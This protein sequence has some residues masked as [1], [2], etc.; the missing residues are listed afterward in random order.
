M[1]HLKIA[2]R[3]R[4]T[5]DTSAR[6]TL[7]PGLELTVELVRSVAGI[8][9]LQADYAHLQAV[10]GNTLPFGLYEWHL[11]WC[12]HFLGQD[13]H[14][15]DRPVFHVLRNAEGVCVAIIPLIFSQRRV[16]AFQAASIGLLGADPAITEIHTWL[17]Q[18]GY[19]ECAAVA[20]HARLRKARDW[21][22]LQWSGPCDEF[23]AALAHL[24]GFRWQPAAPS[25]VLDLP[26]T[27]DEFRAG[28]KRNIRESLRH[29][30]NSLKRDGHRFEFR[31]AAEPGAVRQALDRLV[32]L[33]ALR[34]AMPGT[35]DHPDR[36]AHPGLR[37]FVYEVC[38]ALAA[39]G[40]AR[41]FQLEIGGQIVAARVGFVVGASLYLYYSGFDPAWARYSV[42]TT[43]VA[44][45]LKY[46][47][48]QRLETVNLS[49]G[50]DISKTRWGP[51][52]VPHQVA[53]EHS[54]RLRSRLVRHAYLKAKSGEG[55]Q[56]WLLQRLAPGRRTWH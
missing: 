22:W 2:K 32:E 46:A 33:H 19:E 27:W 13:P 36:F 12:R 34:A 31:V 26:A 35:V 24:R 14:I 5:V 52:E 3:D 17:V 48:A 55:V 10:T 44:E 6:P 50:N 43:A 4:P 39:R 18:P 30:Y 53:Y 8:A 41:V 47:I 9:R 42:M 56:G 38:E 40:I 21:D 20:L 16:G 1:V 45:A 23:G 28:L 11:I 37:R 25:Y 54:G 49:P 29:C 7:P 51:R 15:V